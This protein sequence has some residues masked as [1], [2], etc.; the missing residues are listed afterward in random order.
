MSKKPVVLV[1]CTGNSAR[2]QMA[3]ALLR[4]HVGDRF[5]VHSAG[6]TP[7]DEIHPLAIEVLGEKGLDLRESRPKHFSQFL[8]KLPVHTLVIVCDGANRSCPSVWPGALERLFWPFEDP[9]AFEGFREEQVEKFRQVR[10]AIES[11]IIDWSAGR[12]S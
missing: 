7:A 4:K 3:E 5:E 10:D 11:R 12:R 2:S 9:A 1:L 8:G 6:T